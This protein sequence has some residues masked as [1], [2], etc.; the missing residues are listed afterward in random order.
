MRS[1]AVVTLFPEVDTEKTAKKVKQ[2]LRG[3]FV[4]AIRL[5]GY[6]LNSLSSPKLSLAPAHGATGNVIE[7][8]IIRSLEAKTIVQAV[9]ESIFRCT[10]TSRQIL[11][12]IYIEEKP[13]FQV[14]RLVQYQHTQFDV[15]HKRALNEFADRFEYWQRILCVKDPEDLHVYRGNDNE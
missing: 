15:M 7:R 5:S 4:R 13:I 9:H 6:D 11:I 12:G 1:V 8:Q 14:S 3:D 2:F 10:A